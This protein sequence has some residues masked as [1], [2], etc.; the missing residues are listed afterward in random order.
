MILWALDEGFLNKQTDRQTHQQTNKQQTL[1]QTNNKQ[2]NKK[3]KVYEITI[4]DHYRN[5]Q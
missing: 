3:Q 1:Q 4:I 5:R 2:T